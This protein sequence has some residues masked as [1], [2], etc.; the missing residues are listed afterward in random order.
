[1]FRPLTEDRGAEA[2]AQ[3][4]EHGIGLQ[5]VGIL[6][7]KGFE[8]GR[9]E[10]CLGILFISL[11]QVGAFELVHCLIVH[12]GQEVEGCPLPAIV[13]HQLRIGQFGHLTE[14]DVHGVESIDGDAVVG[15]RVGPGAGD[16]GV[17][18]GQNLGMMSEAVEV[19]EATLADLAATYPEE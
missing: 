8:G 5:P 12:L 16:G 9:S 4:G 18:D 1:M 2:V 19:A 15:I 11:A 7:K 6:L 13:V 10:H 14:V 3:A 17:V